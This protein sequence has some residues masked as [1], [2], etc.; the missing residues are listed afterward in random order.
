MFLMMKRVFDDWRYRRYEWKCDS[1]NAPSVAA[2]Q[3]LG[4]RYEGLFRNHVTMKGRNR[5]TAWFSITREEWPAI[6]D[7]MESWLDPRNFDDRGVQR[8][9]LG[10]W[11]PD[12]AGQAI[13]LNAIGDDA[14]V[15]TR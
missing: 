7:A 8:K 4:F 13:V 12:T 11:M 2:A 5:D 3:R 10:E 14:S 6:R 15:E 9:R 1:L